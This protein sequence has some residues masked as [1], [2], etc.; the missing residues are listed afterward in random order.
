MW[1][2]LWLASWTKETWCGWFGVTDK[3]WQ[4]SLTTERAIV[5]LFT[6]LK[7]KVWEIYWKEYDRYPE[8]GIDQLFGQQNRRFRR[9][10]KLFNQHDTYTNILYYNILWDFRYNRFIC[11][12]YPIECPMKTFKTM[13][14]NIEYYLL[15]KEFF[16][17]HS[18]VPLSQAFKIEYWNYETNEKCIKQ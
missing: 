10:K 18:A 2:F 8:K 11:G 12:T 15:N 5:Q 7:K 17:G 16:F 4:Y 13:D 9:P 1:V 14:L 6:T 3:P